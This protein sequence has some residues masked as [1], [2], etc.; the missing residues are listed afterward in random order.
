MN[1][2][3][4]AEELDIERML[5]SWAGDI[6]IRRTAEGPS[7]GWV[8]ALHMKRDGEM[9]QSGAGR[10]FREAVVGV[11]AD[12]GLLKR[13]RRIPTWPLSALVFFVCGLGMVHGAINA[14]IP[15]AACGLL[16]SFAALRL[17]VMKR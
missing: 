14:D 8:V 17:L 6:E 2:P 16:G 10:T 4:T 11:F 1:N 3:D 9:H 5:G 12:A 13:G 15:L 7:R